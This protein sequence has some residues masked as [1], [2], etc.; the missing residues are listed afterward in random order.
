MR[1]RKRA[2]R[3]KKGETERRK[4]KKKGCGWVEWVD[5]QWHQE[6]LIGSYKNRSKKERGRGHRRNEVARR[7]EGGITM[8][9]SGVKWSGVEERKC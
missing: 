2:K 6:Q 1:E 9:W 4:K 8:P 3:S 7:C 5:G